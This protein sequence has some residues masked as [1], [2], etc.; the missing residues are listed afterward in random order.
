MKKLF[1]I[2]AAAFLI[3]SAAAAGQTN[4]RTD[5]FYGYWFIQ[6][7]GGIGHTVGESTF[8]NLISPAASFNFGYRFTPVWEL[9]AGI[10]GWQAKGALVNPTEI[11]RYNYL[12]G[13]VDVMADIC[14]MF[15]GYRIS[16]AVSPYL[17]AGVGVNGAFCNDQANSLKAYF[18]AGSYLW[19]GSRISPVGR[20]GI[21]TDI[22]IVDAVHFNLEVGA[23]FLSDHFNSKQGDAL[24]WQLTAQAGFTFNIGLKKHKAVRQSAPAPVPA[25]VPEEKPA[26]APTPAPEPKPEPAP[27]PVAE[28]A[29]PSAPVF[30]AQKRD[31]FFR[32]G[33]YELRDQETGKLEELATMAKDNPETKIQVTGYAD[34]QTGTAERNMY[35]S[36]KRAEAVASW[37]EDN[38][39]AAD[40]ITVEYRGSEESPYGTP[41]ENRVAVCVIK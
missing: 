39:V 18:P 23:N 41:E 15:S 31:I 8:G 30:E 22:R 16:R 12:Q 37:L 7:Q 24:D 29:A 38:G 40:R 13:S 11:Y 28:E 4:D 6:A 14:S 26:P 10:G 32:I 34:P 25:P 1:T 19:E 17:F 20:F 3:G 5:D 33:R 21:G 35:L 27:V 9:R 2:C 36:Q